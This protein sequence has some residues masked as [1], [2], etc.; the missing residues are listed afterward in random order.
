MAQVKSVLVLTSSPRPASNS[1]ELAQRV[2]LGCREAGAEVKTFH[3]AKMA[4]YP[5]EACDWCHDNVGQA[6]T[7]DDDMKDVYPLL[8]EADAIVLATPVYCFTMS[9]QLKLLLDRL[10][11]LMGESSA[12]GA[13]IFAGKKVALCLTFG[14]KDVLVSGGVNAIRAVEDLAKYLKM[15]YVG[16]IYGTANKPGE[17]VSNGELLDYAFQ[18]GLQLAQAS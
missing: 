12:D 11:A 10:Y 14:D 16:S 8:R 9:A 15:D 6:C 2:A 7:I 3:L 4:V 13:S 1:T 5:C 18:F 17:I